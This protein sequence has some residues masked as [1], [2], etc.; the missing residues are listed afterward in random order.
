MF[1]FLVPVLPDIKITRLSDTSV[2]VEWSFKDDY[3]SV[4]V[5]ITYYKKRGNLSD[6]KVKK[7]TAN[8]TDGFVIIY[9]LKP[10]TEYTFQVSYIM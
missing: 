1:L 10:D 7:V 8:T 3:G 4:K 6:I 5:W 9:K 2:K